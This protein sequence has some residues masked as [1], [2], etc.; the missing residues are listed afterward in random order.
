MG[1]N[2]GGTLQFKQTFEFSRQYSKVWPDILTNHSI[3]TN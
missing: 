3:R 1:L 2:G